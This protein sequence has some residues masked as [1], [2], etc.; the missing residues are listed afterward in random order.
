MEAR[1]VGARLCFQGKPDQQTLCHA[2]DDASVVA[3][4][5]SWL[6]L[7][8]FRR[9]QLTQSAVLPRALCGCEVQD[10]SNRS[11][12]KLSSAVTRSIWGAGGAN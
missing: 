6:P 1:V 3:V 11:L 4:R 5:V 10:F 7:G 2:I 9:V 12:G 8:F